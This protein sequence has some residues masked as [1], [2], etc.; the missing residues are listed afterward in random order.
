MTT[1]SLPPLSDG[2]KS[3][4]HD[5]KMEGTA[6]V[7]AQV[8]LSF[9]TA[10]SAGAGE[11][12][13]SVL[14]IRNFQ[15]AQ[16]KA[17]REFKGMESVIQCRDENGRET[18]VSHKVRTDRAIDDREPTQIRTAQPISCV[19]AAAHPSLIF[20]GASLT[21]SPHSPSLVSPFACL[22]LSVRRHGEVGAAADGR[23]ARRARER[24]LPASG[25]A[26]GRWGGR[27]GGR[28]T[29]DCACALAVMRVRC[30]IG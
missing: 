22:L 29:E 21:R 8:K 23:V 26:A 14:A 6:L 30:C 7:K 16:K 24:H 15:L 27:A 10:A 17:K 28:E 9:N 13:Q 18:S 12:G 25:R 4:V 1:G 3:F 20:A 11:R 2:G 19:A 5:P